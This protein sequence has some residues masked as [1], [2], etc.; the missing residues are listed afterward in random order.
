MF[1]RLACLIMVPSLLLA[2][3]APETPADT[4]TIAAPE[5]PVITTEKAAKT[6]VSASVTEA[7]QLPDPFETHFPWDTTNADIQTTDS[8]LQYIVLRSSDGSGEKPGLNDRATV[9]YDGRLAVDGS[10]FDSSYDRGSPATFGVTQVI[11]GWTEALQLMKPGDDWMVYLPSEIAYGERGT[12]GGP[13]GP[14]AD[15][16]FRVNLVETVK[17]TTPGADIF[18]QNLPWDPD[19]TDIKTLENG[20]QYVALKTGDSGQNS[21]TIE[22]QVSQQFEIRLAS[23]GR[24]IDSTFAGAGAQTLAVGSVIPGWSAALQAM[25]PGD[26][27]LCYLPAELAFGERGTPGGPIGPNEDIVMRISL[28][29]IVVP[30]VSDTN[31]WE[32]YTPWNSEAEN[33]TKTA[34]GLEYIVL[35]SGDTSGQK[36]TP[37]NRVEVYYEGKLTTGE[38]FDSAYQRGESIEFGVTQVIPGWTEALQLMVPGDRWLVYI[39]SEIAYGQTPRPGGIIKPGDDL[40]FEMQL[41]SVR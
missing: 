1:F 14:N 29:K 17:D 36:P 6:D 3:C 15:L 16:V 38:T 7:D 12:P 35:Q 10:K 28:E 25:R 5:D 23:N 39:P 22:D 4:D 26:D 30:E 8:G 9:H 19:R 40:I 32:Q 2:S 41:V 21:P 24:R 33:V 34:S 11:P 31:A 27:W 18:D 37:A 13:I 20:L